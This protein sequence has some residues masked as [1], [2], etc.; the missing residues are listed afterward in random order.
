LVLWLEIIDIFDDR[1]NVG[2]VEHLAEGRHRAFLPSLDPVAKE[3]IVSLG[4]HQLRASSG[5]AAAIAVAEA[6][7]GRKQYFDI[8]G[9]LRGRWHRLL[10]QPNE[11]IR[12]ALRILRLSG[13]IPSSAGAGTVLRW[14]APERRYFRL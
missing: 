7:I 1:S 10:R 8:E 3:F 2:L 13:L 6:A 11:T 14:P 9:G 4:V 12:Q 5:D